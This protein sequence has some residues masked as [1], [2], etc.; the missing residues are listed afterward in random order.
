MS[1]EMKIQRYVCTKCGNVIPTVLN[2]STGSIEPQHKNCPSC[3]SD[4]IMLVVETKQS[5]NRRILYS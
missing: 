2:E 1:E 5:D 3:T 4:S